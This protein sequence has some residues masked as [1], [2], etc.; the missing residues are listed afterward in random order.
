M[1]NSVEA[2]LRAENARLAREL[3]RISHS[4]TERENYFRALVDTSPAIL[5]ITDSE[6]RC[7][8]LSQQ[9]YEYTG[10][11]PGA[12]QGDGW[13][14]PVHPE[15]REH[16]AREFL[17]AT[18]QQLPFY[19]EHRLER[20]GEGYR[21]CICTGNPRRDDSGRYLGMVGTIID[22]HEERLA[23]ER[24]VESM[25]K[26]E[27][28][29]KMTSDLTMALTVREIAEIVVE[30]GLPA[31][32]ADAGS[33]C[34]IDSSGQFLEVVHSAGYGQ[35]LVER[36][37]RMNLQGDLPLIRAAVTGITTVVQPGE[38][39]SDN[40][41]HETS[42]NHRAL[43]SSAIKARGKILG[44]MGVTYHREEK[45]PPEMLGLLDTLTDLCGQALDRAFSFAQEKRA[46][47]AAERANRLK[48][49]FLAN[50]SHEIRT[51]L[52]AMIGFA[53]LLRDPATTDEERGQYIDILHR[54]GQQ[55]G[56]I[57]NDILDFSKIEVGHL[58]FEHLPV[59]PMHVVQDVVSL[60]SVVAADKGVRLGLYV[61]PSAP[62]E[63][64]TDPV[65]LK[66]IVTN[67][68][69]NALKFTHVG[70]VSIRMTGEEAEGKSRVLIEISDTGIGIAPEG[71]GRLFQ[72]F[73]QADE[74]LTRR[75]GGT[76]LGLS[77]S[78][79]LARGMGGDVELV[80]TSV[81]EGSVFLIT[82]ESRDDRLSSAPRPGAELRA[83]SGKKAAKAKL[84]EG[85]RVLL[86]EDSTDNQQLISR[87]LTRQ[88]AT[89]ELAENGAEG[90]LQALQGDHD[91]VLMDLQM[92]LMDGYTATAKLR[93]TGY[94]RPI[95]ALTAH[96]MADIRKRCV[97]IGF[98]DHLPKPINASELTQALARFVPE[99]VF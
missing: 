55:L 15:E 28:L 25:R 45:V 57:I 92:P 89:L 6:G 1:E 26:L 66:Q 88:G 24:S 44:A 2:Q 11:P 98:N 50:M 41:L 72:M 60:L 76:G 14:E 13:S 32:G 40:E 94:K 46:R 8:Y 27:R 39:F 69:T 34:L 83:E 85:L 37:E 70:H 52:G 64:V 48:S 29:Q 22:V 47:E 5:W 87:Y 91:V 16:A 65:R 49:A 68:V 9:W 73:T 63:I 99:R 78:R 33:V 90:V 31:V 62:R 81:G 20:L 53:D 23:R 42:V 4:I 79:S 84:L 59:S 10:R 18:R 56:H 12:G 36:Y 21:W 80:R 3:S 93:S 38:S 96:A 61:D 54:N 58:T 74:S 82:I 67:L 86:V 97:D 30:Q 77:L 19:F 71:V 43:V 17:T 51:P 95:I 75:Y 35:A 7:L